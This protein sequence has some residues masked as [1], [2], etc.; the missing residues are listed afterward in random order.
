MDAEDV[1]IRA[2]N[3]AYKQLL[4]NREVNGRPITEVFSGEHLSELIQVLKTAAKEG[5]PVHT[6]PILAS[7]ETDQASIATRLIHT[8]VPIA[9]ASG[10]SVTR[11][12]VYSEKVEESGEGVNS[13]SFRMM[14]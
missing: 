13:N 1:T 2:V 5:Q 6:D 9:D 10:S 14:L 4:G 11:L 7:F 3:P 8:I 12:F